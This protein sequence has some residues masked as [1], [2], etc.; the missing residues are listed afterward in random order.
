MKAIKKYKKGGKMKGS[1]SKPSIDYN[2]Y[3]GATG[4]SMSQQA[5]ETMWSRKASADE[6]KLGSVT[7]RDSSGNYITRTRT[8]SKA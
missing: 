3:Q 5:A 8:S 7:T 4:K 1:S 6:L 2:V